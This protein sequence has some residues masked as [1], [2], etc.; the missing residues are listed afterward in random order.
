MLLWPVH[1]AVDCWHG[2]VFWLH[3]RPWPL[4]LLGLPAVIIG[5]AVAGIMVFE[6][7]GADRDVVN[8]YRFGARE[9]VEQGDLAAAHVLVPKLKE[10]APFD[11]E[12]QYVV[13]RLAE[14]EGD[15]PTALER[16]RELAPTDT[17]G[18]PA[19]HFWMAMRM[20]RDKTPLDD[21]EVDVVVHHLTQALSCDYH[22]R[23]AHVLLAKICIGCGE[24]EKAIEHLEAVVRARPELGLS[25]SVVYEAIGDTFRAR[26][27]RERAEDYF[28][29]Q[30]ESD[31]TNVKARILLAQA[32]A[33]GGDCEEAASILRRGL[34]I[35]DNESLRRAL[36][37]VSDS[38]DL[39]DEERL[40]SLFRLE[41]VLP[42]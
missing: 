4:L 29:E 25:L 39:A 18:C 27:E 41:G 38:E 22:R 1:F 24:Y 13:A 23:D 10:L 32:V 33:L 30:L 9:A 42:R 16:M 40:D 28:R 19:A 20:L 31:D 8:R 26:R 5:P 35:A 15:L 34:A 21:A 3:T 7:S 36:A 17:A 6:W 37:D 11:P 2:V 14:L 12:T